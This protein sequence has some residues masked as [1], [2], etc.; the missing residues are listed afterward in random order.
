MDADIPPFSVLSLCCMMHYEKGYQKTTGKHIRRLTINGRGTQS[1]CDTYS[2]IANRLQDKAPASSPSYHFCSTGCML[3]RRL[4]LGSSLPIGY[5]A[6]ATYL[7]SDF[8]CFSRRCLRA[9]RSVQFSFSRSFGVLVNLYSIALR[10]SHFEIPLATMHALQTNPHSLGLFT[11]ASALL[12]FDS[13][14]DQDEQRKSADGR[15]LYISLAPGTTG[16]MHGWMVRDI[17]GNCICSHHVYI[18]G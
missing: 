1:P 3:L 13:S 17:R 16:L 8:Y 15:L 2:I 11:C 14:H 18:I 6:W 4:G 12:H 10:Y 7:P 5:C 9:S